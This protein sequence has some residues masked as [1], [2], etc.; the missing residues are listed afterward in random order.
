MIWIILFTIIVIVLYKVYQR[1]AMSE[2]QSFGEVIGETLPLDK[3]VC[4][5]LAILGI[6]FLVLASLFIS[7]LL[8]LVLFYIFSTFFALFIIANVTSFFI[9]KNA[10]IRDLE[11]I[12]Y[13]NIRRGDKIIRYTIFSSMA[14]LLAIVVISIED[15]PINFKKTNNRSQVSKQDISAFIP[16]NALLKLSNH[17]KKDLVRCLKLNDVGV[18]GVCIGNLSE[19]GMDRC[20]KYKRN[21]KD[22]IIFGEIY[23]HNSKKSKQEGKHELAEQYLEWASSRYYSSCAYN[24]Q[25]CLLAY[26]LSHE[27]KHHDEKQFYQGLCTINS[28]ICKKTIKMLKKIKGKKKFS[29][30]HKKGK[31]KVG[32]TKNRQWRKSASSTGLAVRK[33]KNRILDIISL[34][35]S[36]IKK[37]ASIDYKWG[38]FRDDYIGWIDKGKGIVYMAGDIKFQNQYGTYIPHTYECMYNPQTDVLKSRVNMGKKNF[39]FFNKVR[40]MSLYDHISKL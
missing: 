40:Q 3:K 1:E 31:R 32:K 17:W 7:F 24:G 20:F 38:W 15:L 18:L 29:K 22:C 26:E 25:E 36:Q 19:K 14:L 34:C 11:K 10:D 28:K 2:K 21:P 13:E 6:V 33:V 16:K 12:R 35:K 5:G 4:F 8:G 39:S 9:K 37:R 27:E 30:K 23:L